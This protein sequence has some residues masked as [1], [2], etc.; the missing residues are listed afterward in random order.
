MFKEKF[1][2]Y[3]QHSFLEFQIYL[4][5]FFGEI[6]YIIFILKQIEGY[7]MVEIKISHILKI[8]H[9]KTK[10]FYFWETTLG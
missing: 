3:V 6:P 9:E 1:T 7:I 8:K 10:I 4:K 5:I 2:G